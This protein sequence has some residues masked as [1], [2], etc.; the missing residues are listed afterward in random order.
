MRTNLSKVDSPS[1]GLE[2]GQHGEAV[3]TF[4]DVAHWDKFYLDKETTLIQ[5]KFGNHISG[6]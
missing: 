3:Y 4:P 1:T 2:L 6:V 5:S